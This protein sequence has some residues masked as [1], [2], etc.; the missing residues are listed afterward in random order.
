M[1]ELKYKRILLKV[2]GEALGGEAGRGLDFDVIEKVCDVVAR[3]AAEGAQVGIVVGGRSR[4]FGLLGREPDQVFP[5][6]SVK[7]FG[8]DIILVEGRARG[9]R[10]RNRR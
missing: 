10:D 7:R 2:S 6:P 4:L 1:S 3:C 9:T 5:W 8:E